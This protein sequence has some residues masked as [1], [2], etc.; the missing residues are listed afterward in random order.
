LAKEYGS[1]LHTFLAGQDIKPVHICVILGELKFGDVFF[2][3]EAHSL[4]RDA[5]QVLFMAL[6]E[7]KVPVVCKNNRLDRSQFCSVA[8]FTLVLA[9]TEP[10]KI[11]SSLCNRLTPIDFDPYTLPE[12]KAIAMRVAEQEGVEITPQAARHLA[13]ASQGVP[14]TIANHF[15]FMLRPFP[16]EARFDTDHVRQLLSELGIDEHGLTPPQRQYLRVLATSPEGHVP[17]EHLV[18]RLGCDSAHLRRTLEP[19]LVEQGFI[20]FGRARAR[21][22]TPSGRGLVEEML[23]Q[24]AMTENPVEEAVPC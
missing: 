23:A 5:Q 14:R 12:L 21:H 20:G 7:N 16:G 6:D 2:I 10:G 18:A 13:Q 22:I 8:E 15:E 11:L 9:T 4:P 17:L 24:M 3:D 19:Y 1:D